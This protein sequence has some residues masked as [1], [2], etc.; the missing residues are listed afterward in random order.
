M[1]SISLEGLK[2]SEISTMTPLL[3][4]AALVA[5]ANAH[6]SVG[7]Q[8]QMQQMQQQQQQGSDC[9]NDNGMPC[10]MPMI[11]WEEALEQQ[12]KTEMYETQ[13]M[14]EKVKAQFQAMIYEAEMKKYVTVMSIVAETISFC[15]CAAATEATYNAVF[16][17]TARRLNMTQQI[18]SWDASRPPYEAR[19][20]E[21]ARMLIFGG[22]VEKICKTGGELI[23]FADQVSQ[24][25]PFYQQQA[26]AGKRK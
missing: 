8:M 18:D 13:A 16:L 14:A 19:N 23:A 20:E 1:G 10:P 12:R 5:A 17:D 6:N 11:N 15:Q 9:G 26:Q 22:L 7:M 21:E 2:K 4:L 24:R 25:I 3:V